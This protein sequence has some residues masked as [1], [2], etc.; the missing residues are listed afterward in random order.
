MDESG[1]HHIYDT[2]GTP[3]QSLIALNPRDSNDTSSSFVQEKITRL[4]RTRSPGP[5]RKKARR[6][7]WSQGEDLAVIEG[8]RQHGFQW[9]LIA[10]D[11][12]LNLS[13]RTGNQVRDRFRI[14]YPEIYGREAVE[15]QKNSTNSMA[16]RK[17]PLATVGK[18]NDQ[19]EVQDQDQDQDPYDS[20]DDETASESGDPG[21]KCQELSASLGVR[22]SMMAS[23]DIMSLLNGDDE[24][25]R[26]SASLRY[27]G[28]DDNVTLPPLLWEDM[29]TRPMFD[30]E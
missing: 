15:T 11:P 30:L 2:S 12:S 7:P 29:A 28:W 1:T 14:K 21:P 6:K 8:Y 5:K 10:N 22:P 23:F 3:D 13:N 20:D 17:E 19:S 4:R 25:T 27:D 18:S 16:N 26:P 24:D 9:K